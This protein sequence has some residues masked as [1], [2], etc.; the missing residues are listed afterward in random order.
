M[1]RAAHAA[2][3]FGLL[4]WSSTARAEELGV[5]ILRYGH[6]RGEPSKGER[7]PTLK[8]DTL[9]GVVPMRDARIVQP[10]G[11][12]LG[13]YCEGF[14]IEFQVLGLRPGATAVLLVRN[15]HPLLTRPDGAQSEEDVFEIRVSSERS[16]IGFTFAE[17]WSL[18][19]GR[20][21]FTLSHDGKTLA[22]QVFDVERAPD[23][24]SLETNGCAVPVS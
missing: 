19:P 8:E 5:R 3:V 1:R 17:T 22:E 9:S 11:R 20:W 21:S 13:R 6:M 14:G 23:A 15:R 7:D 24:G 18:V 4:L 10:G 12:I 16:W 2:A